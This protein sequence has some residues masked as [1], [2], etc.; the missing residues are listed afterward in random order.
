MWLDV[1]RSVVIT[2]LLLAMD[3][4]LREPIEVL[5]R[6]VLHSRGIPLEAQMDTL[7]HKSRVTGLHHNRILM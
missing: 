5:M 3:R 6:E 7:T 1:Q 2:T 4:V